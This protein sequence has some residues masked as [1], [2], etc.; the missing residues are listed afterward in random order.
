M[1]M[2]R[3]AYTAALHQKLDEETA[4]FHEARNGEELAD[5]LEVL[6]ALAADLGISPKE[7]KEIYEKKHTQRGGFQQRLLLICRVDECL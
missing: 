1:T 2:D 3:Q 6:L 5:I 7:L 4:E